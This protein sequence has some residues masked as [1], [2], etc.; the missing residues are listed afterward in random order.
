MPTCPKC[1]KLISESHYAR[2]IK[3]CGLTHNTRIPSSTLAEK[4]AS[5]F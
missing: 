4:R 3:R 2:H 5:P 1:H